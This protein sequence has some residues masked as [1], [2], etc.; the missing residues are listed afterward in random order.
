MTKQNKTKVT[1]PVTT[2]EVVLSTLKDFGTKSSYIRYLSS[3]GMSRSDI[4]K[5]FE[6][7]EG[8]KIRYQ[9]VRNVLTQPLKR[10]VTE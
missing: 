6:T 1:Q 3:T 9:H 4:C 10:V 2:T 5:R 8:M 7:V